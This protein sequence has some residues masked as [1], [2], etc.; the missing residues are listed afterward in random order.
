MR[1]VR[2]GTAEEQR[3]DGPVSPPE[4]MGP[5]VPV[6]R[7]SSLDQSLAIRL[8]RLHTPDTEVHD[9]HQ[10]QASREAAPQ[11]RSV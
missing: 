11:G 3:D 6:M 4:N 8:A 2:L 1:K 5:C 9:G 10:K 7:K